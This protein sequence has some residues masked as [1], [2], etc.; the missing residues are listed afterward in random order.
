MPSLGLRPDVTIVTPVYNEEESLPAYI[1]QVRKVLLESSE[2]TFTVLVV[3]DGSSDG[4]WEII[5]RQCAKDNR[6]QALR[7]SRNFGSHTALSAGFLHAFGDA[8]CVLACD[9]QDPPEVILEFLARWRHGA[10]IVWGK[11]MKREDSAW[12]VFFSN[13]FFYLVKRYAMPKESRFT[14]G[15]FFLADRQVMECYHQFKE[16]NRITFAL[17]A[18]TG[19]SQDFVCYDR[20]IRTAG[21]SKWNFSK[22]LKAMYDTFFGFS[23]APIRVITVA[24][25]TISLFSFFLLVYFVFLWFSRNPVPGY[26]SSMVTIL[27]MFGIQFLFMGIVGEYLYRIY[28]ET[29]RRPL[30][31]IS[32][33]LNH[34]PK[35]HA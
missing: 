22:M 16:H 7:L 4:S 2:Y 19:F 9:L 3:D 17:M 23:F 20:K 30:F 29:L 14:T 6:F 18:W 26:T 21:K 1:N 32:E 24:G 27:F 33:R 15:S 13:L 25:I 31:F 12:R 10:K 11:R 28:V 35:D 5:R 34:D 8:V